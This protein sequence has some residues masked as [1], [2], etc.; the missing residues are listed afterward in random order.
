M[1]RIRTIVFVFVPIYVDWGSARGSHALCGGSPQ[2]FNL[3]NPSDILKDPFGE[4]PNDAREARALP[5]EY[6]FW[7]W[8][9][10]N[11]RPSSP[12]RG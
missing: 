3:S 1:K 5:R 12:Y 9:V 8:F 11:P 6:P 10:E 2:S 4:A 7:T